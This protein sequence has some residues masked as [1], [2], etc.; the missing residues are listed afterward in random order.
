MLNTISDLSL[1][2][3]GVDPDSLI[4]LR[5]N[6][7]IMGIDLM[8]EGAAYDAIK[9]KCGKKAREAKSALSNAKKAA[10]K[11]D[12]DTAYAEY[13]KA[14]DIYED[15]LKDCDS[16][17]DDSYYNMLAGVFLKSFVVGLASAAPVFIPMPTV[18]QILAT[19]PTAFI[20][21]KLS[22]KIGLKGAERW[23]NAEPG[24][25]GKWDLKGMTRAELK[26]KYKDLIK[27]AKVARS[28]LKKQD[29]K[30]D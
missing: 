4:Y 23:N 29:V 25:E 7:A 10:K 22:T 16:I 2:S 17:K 26:Q 18:L 9:I 5:E 1:I 8:N 20:G 24:K 3:E 21:F 12:L 19:I 27:S 14:I 30:D 28:E 6:A 11:D 15:I 13:T